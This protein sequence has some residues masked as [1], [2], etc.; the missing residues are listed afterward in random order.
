MKDTD[1]AIALGVHAAHDAVAIELGTVF[2]A[3]VLAAAV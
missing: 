2:E 1:A 3:G